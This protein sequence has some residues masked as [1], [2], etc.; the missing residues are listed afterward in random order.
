MV[1]VWLVRKVVG[2]TPSSNPTVTP[3]A[4]RGAH[5]ALSAYANPAPR[6]V[7]LLRMCWLAWPLPA[8]EKQKE[9]ECKASEAHIGVFR[10]AKIGSFSIVASMTTAALVTFLGAFLLSQSSGCTL[11]AWKT[12]I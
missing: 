2:S 10:L 6:P 9:I 1:C 7:I 4:L 12:V 11:C 8:W 5:K 3:R